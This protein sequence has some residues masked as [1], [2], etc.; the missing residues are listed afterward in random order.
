MTFLFTYGTLRPGGTL[1]DLS[2]GEH[3]G[4]GAMP[5][6]LHRHERARFP[7]LLDAADTDTDE[8]VGDIF[9]V[10][11]DRSRQL[12][13][14]LEMEAGAGYDV[15]IREARLSASGDTVP[16]IVFVWPDRFPVGPRIHCGDWF[17]PEAVS[18]CS[19]LHDGAGFVPRTSS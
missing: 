9:H 12:D 8:V 16:C 15:R 19:Q 17:S 11:T 3:I 1:S 13:F 14:V 7:V 4:R 10:S 5:G 18:V 2:P 6:R